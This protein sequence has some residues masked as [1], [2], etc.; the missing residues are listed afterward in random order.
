MAT[1]VTYKGQTLA[2]VE[3]QTK[4]LQT[5][6][7]WVEDDFTLTDVSGGG[8]GN[9][10]GGDGTW[11]RPMGYPKLD[12]MDITGGDVVYISYIATEE[13][14]FCDLTINRTSGS[15]TFEIGEINNGVFTAD[16][17]TTYSANT[18][19]KKYFGSADGGYKVI[20]IAGSIK[21]ITTN[22][23]D[24]TTYDGEYRFSGFQGIV[25][26]YGKLPHMT[27]IS[28]YGVGRL[29][30]VHLGNA[31][32]TTLA[33]AFYNNY[34]LESVD[35][36]NWDVSNCTEFNYT[37]ANCNCLNNVDV[38]TWNTGKVTTC[39]AMFLSSG[40][41]QIDI[42]GW[43]MSL[44]T[45]TSQMFQSVKFT[46]ITIPASLGTISANMF[47]GDN[48]K[49]AYHFKATTVPTL[50]NVNA[51]N[52]YHTQMV[53]YVPTAKLSDYQTASNWSTY[54]SYMVGE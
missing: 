41:S 3:N 5:A 42:S 9:G 4:T 40:I 31:P 12:D 26:I 36:K 47:S 18:R 49:L 14:G 43:N 30:A 29:H 11:T 1:T 44:V 51:F 46:E 27:K 28:F 23:T 19:I 16:S 32:F 37:F 53:I 35:T 21:E 38:S 34:F 50:A 17:S 48:Q 22:R 20:K 24:W 33:S 7:T 54:A 52:G 2:T 6:G 45:N 15:F 39:Q 13:L 10:Y 25:E 8:G